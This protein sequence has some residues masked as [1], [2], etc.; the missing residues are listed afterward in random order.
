MKVITTSDDDDYLY[1]TYDQSLIKDYMAL[2]E[3]CYATHSKRL[4]IE[5]DDL[6]AQVLLSYVQSTPA[7]EHRKAIQRTCN[8]TYQERVIAMAHETEE[9]VIDKIIN[10]YT[11]EDMQHMNSWIG[12]KITDIA[13]DYI[14]KHIRES[15]PVDIKGWE[16]VVS[17]ALQDAIHSIIDFDYIY[18]QLKSYMNEPTGICG[19]LR[20]R[21]MTSSDFY[22]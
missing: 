2:A 4:T 12:Q 16:D 7:L 6:V 11:P 10:T 17:D 13:A 8:K 19:K 20:E 22:E 5:A 14:A 18:E 15:F 3:L 21:G 9:Y 1:Y